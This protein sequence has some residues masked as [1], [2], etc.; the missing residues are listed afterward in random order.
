MANRAHLVL[1][2]EHIEQVHDVSVL[3]ELHDGNVIK[4]SQGTFA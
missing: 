2:D 4:L 1:A 3:D